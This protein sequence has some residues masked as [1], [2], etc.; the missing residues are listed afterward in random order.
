MYLP[1]LRTEPIPFGTKVIGAVFVVLFLIVGI[2]GVILPII[3]GLLFLFLALYVLTRISRRAAAMAHR[4]P[5]FSRYA[6]KLDSA[7]HL[8]VLTR[9]KLAGL[10]IA[11]ATVSGMQ[12]VVSQVCSLVK[13]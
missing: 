6:K 8:P 5:W 12:L 9:I 2:I 11:A 10:V 3:P 7:N 13:R 1:K 4:Q